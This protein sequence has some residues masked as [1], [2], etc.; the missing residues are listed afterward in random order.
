LT[1]ISP[2]DPVSGLMLPIFTIAVEK[3]LANW[4]L[5]DA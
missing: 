5:L 4:S 3:S 2:A 1:L